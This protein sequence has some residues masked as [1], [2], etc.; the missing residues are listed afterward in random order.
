MVEICRE[1]VIRM[2]QDRAIDSD[3]RCVAVPER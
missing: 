1:A 3:S 2:A